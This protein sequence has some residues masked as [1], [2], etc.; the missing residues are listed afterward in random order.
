MLRRFFRDLAGIIYPKICPGCK[1]KIDPQSAADFICDSCQARIKL[2]LPP[3]C[4]KCGRHLEASSLNTGSCPNCLVRKFNFDR[5]FSPC[6]FEGITKEL[7]HGFKYRG[8]EYLAGPLSKIMINFIKEYHI[9]LEHLDLII[10]MPLHKTRLREREFN[11]A[12][13]LGVLIGAEFNKEIDSSLLMRRRLTKTQTELPLDKRFQNAQ[14]SFSITKN[15][16]LKDKN[17]LII[18]DVLTTG[19]TAS[20]AAL[21]LKEAGANKI[22][23]LTL[24]N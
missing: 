6:I 8:K 4:R 12:E 14:E 18:D 16:R 23:I 3:F 13:A 15:A 24:A 17:L 21:A 19:A 9:P 2:N 11:Q 10:P 1:N 5:A 7:I 20:A 22:L